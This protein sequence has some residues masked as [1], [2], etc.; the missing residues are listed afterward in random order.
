MSILASEQDRQR[1]LPLTGAVNFRDLGGYPTTD[2]RTIAW[3]RLYRSDSLADL[4]AD[5]IEVI[6]A[7]GLKRIFDLRDTEERQRRPSRLPVT[8]V[9]NWHQPGFMLSG[10]NDLIRGINQDTITP[11]EAAEKLKSMYRTALV[12]NLADFRNIILLLLQDE[13]FP[14]LVHCTSGKDRTGIL[15]MILLMLLGVARDHILEDYKLTN[16]YQRD[17]SFM[18]SARANPETVSAVRSARPEFLQATF[19]TIDQTWGGTD[20]FLNNGLGITEKQRDALRTRL[21]QE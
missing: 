1:R 20:G 16:S 8:A 4:T 7:L 12:A 11:T 6:S 18:L 15:V 5:D 13:E 3:Q 2:G 9:A 14:A 21:L 19:D 17:L 10:G